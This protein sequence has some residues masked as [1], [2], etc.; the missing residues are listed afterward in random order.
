VNPGL[1][2]IDSKLGPP[3]P[4]AIE[5]SR[6]TAAPQYD[7][8]AFVNP[9]RRDFGVS[10]RKSWVPLASPW[11]QLGGA[12][13]VQVFSKF[14][15]SLRTDAAPLTYVFSKHAVRVGPAQVWRKFWRKLR[16]RRRV[17]AG[18]PQ[19]EFSVNSGPRA[20]N[21]SVKTSVNCSPLAGPPEAGFGTRD[22]QTK[23]NKSGRGRQHRV[24]TPRIIRNP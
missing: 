1:V 16:T 17:R 15:A 23:H 10:C 9:L 4:H 13:L 14:G 6:A 2:G 5:Y 7:V 21:T 3:R 20:A 22:P 8:A 24:Y 19:S 18:G 11:E 12:S